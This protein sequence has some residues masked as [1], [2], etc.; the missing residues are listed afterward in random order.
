[1]IRAVDVVGL[2]GA[3][4]RWLV[5]AA[6]QIGDFVIAG[7]QARFRI[8][9]EDND[10]CFVDGAA[11]LIARAAARSRH[12]EDASISSSSC[13]PPVSTTVN[14]TPPQSVVP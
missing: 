1:M 2:V 3:E 14:S 9:H 8:D 7:G 4:N 13:R 11:G 12:V 6:Q 5:G 10:I